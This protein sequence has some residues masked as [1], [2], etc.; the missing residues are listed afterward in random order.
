MKNKLNLLVL[1]FALAFTTT[2][3]NAANVSLTQTVNYEITAQKVIDYLVQ[4][5]YTNVSV[6]EITD[7][8]HYICR[9]DSDYLTIVYVE[10]CSIVGSE[11]ID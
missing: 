2:S 9:S 7:E 10:K 3:I 1:M 11:E 6:V 8:G 4:L 5:G